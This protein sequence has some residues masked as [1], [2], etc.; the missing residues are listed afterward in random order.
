MR[1]VK[2]IGLII[3]SVIVA[4]CI[5]S[6][7][8][9]SWQQDH[10]L[11]PVP[12][13]EVQRTAST[14]TID[15]HLQEESWLKAAF[16]QDFRLANDSALPQNRTR[17]KF[18]WDSTFLYVGFECE[19]KN[20]IGRMTKRDAN[21]WEEEAVEVFLSPDDTVLHGYTEIEISPANTILDLF[22]RYIKEVNGLPAPVSLPY[23]T[24]NLDIRS[25]ASVRGTIN[26]EA[27]KDT[28]WTVEIAI[29]FRD[30]MPAGTA[31]MPRN[32][33]IWRVNL[34][35]MERFP[36][37]EFIAWSPTGLSKFHVPKRFGELYFSTEMLEK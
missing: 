3:L 2:K 18:L 16:T 5:V 33:E 8:V 22:V 11:S 10:P 35:R 4:F 1:S 30:I 7:T 24:L 15:G 31:T 20:I 32:G 27:D 23:H 12:R 19:D 36:L 17:A 34:Y 29:P 25:A 28:S 21:L 37:R 9:H 13:Y 6:F 14:I 26:N